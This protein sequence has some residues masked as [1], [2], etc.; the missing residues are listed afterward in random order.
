[1]SPAAVI[2]FDGERT[3][4]Y[5]TSGDT[6]LLDDEGRSTVSAADLAVAVVDEVESGAHVG[7]RF[8]VGY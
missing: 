5:R 6:L 2:V 4:R 7:A 3:G 1:V 8:A